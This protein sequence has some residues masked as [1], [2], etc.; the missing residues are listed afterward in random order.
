MS[1]RIREIVSL[2]RTVVE[3]IQDR[4]ITFLA[5]SISYYALVSLV[6]LLVLA[7]VVTTA[8]GGAELQA[9]LEE[10]INQYLVPAGQGIVQRALEDQTGQGSIGI[11]S[12]GLSVWGALKLFRGL[13]IAFSRIYGSESGGILD[14]LKDGIIALVSIGLGTVGVA[15]LTALIALLELPFVQYLS[16]L[17]LFITLCVAFFPL[18]YVFPDMKLRPRQVIPGTLVAAVGWTLLGVGFGIYTQYT[19]GSIAGALGSVLLLVTW[20]YFSGVILLAGAV[21][22]AVLLGDS[23]EL[24]VDAPENGP[25]RGG[26]GGDHGSEM[27]RQVQ[28]QGVR[29]EGHTDM[30]DDRGDND[31]PH[32]GE[33]AGDDQP[34]SSVSPR[35]AP[36][37]EELES[38]VEELRADL[39][40]FESDVTERTVEKP[41]LEAEMK[42]YVRRRMRRGKAR[43]WGPYLVLLYGTVLTLGAFYYL[44]SDLIAVFAMLVIF[45]STLGLYVLFVIFGIGLNALGVPSRAVDA[46]RERRS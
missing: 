4:E 21:V 5:A 17:V 27:D 15:A 11:V 34:N 19:A 45:L 37:I 38:R 32:G 26:D 33:G 9:Q 20:F 24:P 28:H 2:A 42:R 44:Q 14:Q 46:V 6:P 7:V 16:P 12:L 41:K 10:L 1:A 30:S 8:I 13:D 3:T 25:G 36:D 35:G 43:G 40:S 29:H 18:Y 39:D 31:G 22:N 23:D